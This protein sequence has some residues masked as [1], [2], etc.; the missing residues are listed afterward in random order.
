MNKT[1]FVTGI[2]F[3][4][5]AVL[6]GAFGAHGL[7]NLLDG[8][9]IST[10]ET[11]VKYQ[12]YHALFLMILG[13]FNLLVEERKKAVYYLIVAGVICFSF[14]IYLLSTNELSIFDFKKIALLTPI[15]GVLLVSGWILLGI[16][17]HKQN[18][19]N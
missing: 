14:S 16:R 1:I 3:G 4:L 7:E 13:G 12:M 11:G 10:F 5:T 6:L 17:V 2:F 15:G 9:A 18:Q 8:K 19:S